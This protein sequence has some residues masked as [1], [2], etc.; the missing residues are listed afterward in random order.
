[1][2]RNKAGIEKVARIIARRDGMEMADAIEIVQECA[3]EMQA[4]VEDGA[5]IEEI[6]DMILSDLG[7]EPDYIDEMLDF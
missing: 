3:E 2:K 6:Y 5:G 4:A 7:L 1:M